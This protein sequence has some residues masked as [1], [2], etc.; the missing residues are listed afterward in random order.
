MV[1]LDNHSE[2]ENLIHSFSNGIYCMKSQPSVDSNY[3]DLIRSI[4][5]MPMQGN[6]RSILEINRQSVKSLKMICI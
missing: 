4:E 3:C 6:T 2:D 1:Y 5:T